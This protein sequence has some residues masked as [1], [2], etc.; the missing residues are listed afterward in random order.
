MRWYYKVMFWIHCV[1]WP[2][3]QVYFLRRKIIRWK[4]LPMKIERSNNKKIRVI[5][6]AE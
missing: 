3:F 4:S 5:C 6:N 2:W 1:I